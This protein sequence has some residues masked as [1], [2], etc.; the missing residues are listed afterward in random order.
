MN[1]PACKLLIAGPI[2]QKA[3]VPALKKGFF[4][5]KPAA[6]KASTAKA[7]AKKDQ[8]EDVVV[9][10]GKKDVI[11]G[12]APQIPEFMRVQPDEDDKR[13][14]QVRG[15][16]PCCRLQLNAASRLPVQTCP[17]CGSAGQGLSVTGDAAQ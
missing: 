7:T 12:A 3:A 5:S 16:R 14:L 4:N 6:S 9:L 11:S 15:S 17:P 8:E 13:L 2:T 1:G 10:K